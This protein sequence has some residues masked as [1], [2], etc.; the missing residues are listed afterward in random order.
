MVTTAHPGT[1]RDP[2]ATFDPSTGIPTVA[3]AADSRPRRAGEPDFL[4]PDVVRL[5][6]R[7]A[8]R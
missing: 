6:T 7:R 8:I 3:W 4:V 1:V 2:V 5:S